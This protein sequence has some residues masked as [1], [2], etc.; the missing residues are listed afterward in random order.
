MKYLASL[1]LAFG[2][3]ASGIFAQDAGM[4]ATQYGEGLL[5]AL[6][7]SNL[8][9]LADIA[10]NNTALVS[11]RRYEKQG[12]VSASLRAGGVLTASPYLARAC[13]GHRL[14]G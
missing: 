4:S 3:A 8:T 14:D 11:Y 7:M 1:A 12:V 9:M 13:L 5:G 6:R 10:G 2:L